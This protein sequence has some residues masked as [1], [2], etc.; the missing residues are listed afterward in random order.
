VPAFP[1]PGLV[2]QGP[3]GTRRAIRELIKLLKT[4]SH[5]DATT[6]PIG[7]WAEENAPRTIQI[8]VGANRPEYF[9][10]KRLETLDPGIREALEQSRKRTEEME[11][12]M[13]AMDEGRMPLKFP[14]AADAESPKSPE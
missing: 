3:S 11:D 7:R 9:Q 12:F 6:F 2:I 1:G 10:D 5:V 14:G 8:T 4:E 13:D